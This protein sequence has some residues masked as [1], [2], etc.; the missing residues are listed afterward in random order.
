MSKQKPINLSPIC[1]FSDLDLSQMRIC[2]VCLEVCGPWTCQGASTPRFYQRCACERLQHPSAGDSK[3]Q[4]WLRSRSLKAQIGERL[5]GFLFL[6][7][8]PPT[9]F[10]GQTLSLERRIGHEPTETNQSLSDPRF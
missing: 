5:M 8:P 4:T 10:V 9:G 1:A 3:E 2:A 7:C 6:P